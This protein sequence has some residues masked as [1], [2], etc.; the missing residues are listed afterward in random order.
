MYDIG[1]IGGGVIG[2]AIARELSKYDLKVC[3]LERNSDVA[4][5]ATKA[6]SGI[7]HG[8]YDAK[9]GSMKAKFSAPG[10]Q[11]YQQLDDELHFG[12]A[13]IGSFVIGFNAE[14]AA[15]I[16]QIYVNGCKNG[17]QNLQIVDGEFV[18][19][20]EPHLSKDITVALYCPTAGVVSPYE[21][22]I[23]LAENAVENGVD[24]RL[25]AEVVRIKQQDDGF[26]IAI[27]G[28]PQGIQAKR[29]INAAGLYADVIAQM[30]G[31]NDFTISPRQGQYLLFDKDQGDLVNSVI[32]QTPT[33]IS[34]GVLVTKT[35]HNNLLIGPDAE[36]ITDKENLDTA[37]K[38]IAYITAAARKSLPDFDMRKVITAFAGN[39]AVGSKGDFIIE[40]S[41]VKGFINVAGIESPGLTSAPAIAVYVAELLAETGINL[42]QKPNFN[43]HRKPYRTEPTSGDR[44]ICRC[45]TVFESEI[46][47]ALR[48]PIP[49]TTIDAIKRRTRAG[50]GRCQG[51]FCLPKVMQIMC[52]ELNIT[53]EAITK[54][55]PSSP[56]VT[57]KTK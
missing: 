41:K 16:Q 9:H 8:G 5:G 32:F 37:S 18:R 4:T 35:Y 33:D 42:K 31:I 27:A 6:N 43:P 22:A 2:C 51:G 29:V 12:F 54:K 13:K 52:E 47:A 10:N 36:T 55:G 11:M 34:K 17:V 56:I 28:Q 20:K 15:K 53:M 30:V 49:I 50:M 57:G 38:N 26:A 21:V 40:E 44:V 1:I 48:R 19:N 46:R 24:L 45:E 23:A 25:N 3:L 39:R 14:E 7:V